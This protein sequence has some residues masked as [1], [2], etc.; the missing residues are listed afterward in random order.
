MAGSAADARSAYTQVNMS[1]VQQLLQLPDGQCPEM[2]VSLPRYRWPKEWAG[3]ADPVV[4]LLR[5]LDCHPLAGLLW[6]TLLEHQLFNI[7][8]KKVKGWECLYVHPKDKLFLSVY[9]GDFKW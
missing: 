4:P 9:V 8:W 1:M 2:W 3:M 6:E 7:G 5:N